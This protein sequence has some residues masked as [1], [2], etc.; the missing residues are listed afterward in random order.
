MDDEL[1]SEEPLLVVL[2]VLEGVCDPRSVGI[3]VAASGRDRWPRVSLRCPPQGKV[4]VRRAFA[5]GLGKF[6][7]LVAGQLAVVL[8]EG[9]CDFYDPKVLVSSMGGIECHS[10]RGHNAFQSMG[11]R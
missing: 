11:R 8:L 2:E 7:P 9:R 1:P 6:G 4:F 10:L 5:A 3:G